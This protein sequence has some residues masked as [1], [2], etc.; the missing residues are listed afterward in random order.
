MGPSG[1]GSS[2]RPCLLQR[3]PWLSGLGCAYGNGRWRST[4]KLHTTTTSDLTR[5]RLLAAVVWEGAAPRVVYS[6]HAHLSVR[7]R[8]SFL[9][10]I[11]LSCERLCESH[12]PLESVL[13]GQVLFTYFFMAPFPSFWRCKTE[14]SNRSS[15]ASTPVKTVTSCE[16]AELVEQDRLPIGKLEERS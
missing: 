13:L 15:F 3:W 11:L 14:E 1:R 2:H 16:P 6:R 9:L 10:F 7:T 12:R 4:L 5:P 8:F